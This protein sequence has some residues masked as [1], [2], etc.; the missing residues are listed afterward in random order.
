VLA[1]Q[2]VAWPFLVVRVIHEEPLPG[3]RQFWITRPYSWRSL[4]AAKV[5]FMVAF[6]HLPLFVADCVILVW[7]GFSPVPYLPGLL[8]RQ[9]AYFVALIVPAAALAAITRTL[10]E[11]LAALFVSILAF[12]AVTILSHGHSMAWSGG[13][14]YWIPW[15]M[16]FTLWSAA[17]VAILLGQYGRR[18][19][20]LCRV[21]A[22]IAVALTPVIYPSISLAWTIQSHFPQAPAEYSGI[23]VAFD[24]GRGRP[25]Q[26]NLYNPYIPIR[27]TGLPPGTDF[28]LDGAILSVDAPG[29]GRH[30]EFWTTGNLVG[31]G[32]ERWV[33]LNTK[34]TA[35][36][37]RLSL[38]FTVFTKESVTEI[39]KGS[40]R[41]RLPGA[42]MCQSYGAGYVN[43]MAPLRG[44]A[45]MV[46]YS[47]E[48][49]D[50]HPVMVTSG[51]YSP[52]PAEFLSGPVVQLRWTTG[53]SW[54]WRSSNVTYVNERLVAHLVRNLQLPAILLS[55]YMGAGN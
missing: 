18:R 47:P 26:A 2:P 1:L 38:A 55:D 27:I 41:F 15:T 6:L 3:D 54:A 24:P 12:T 19:T 17:G 11:M 37:V 31:Q 20:T 48:E 51:S 44:P 46:A 52:F 49:V 13:G 16:I 45:R 29:E 40:N 5:L 28:Q 10:V 14:I 8:W 50:Q 42:G 23:G 39:P 43:C 34:T 33:E 30:V 7:H 25:A 53:P 4:L 35:K 22:A 32:E 21:I 9:A 36:V